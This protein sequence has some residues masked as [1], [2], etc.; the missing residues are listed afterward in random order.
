M[1][2]CNLSDLEGMTFD[3]LELGAIQVMSGVGRSVEV[4]LCKEAI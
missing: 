4:R 2:S 1:I 3:D